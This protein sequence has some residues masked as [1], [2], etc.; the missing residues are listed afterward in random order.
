MGPHIRNTRHT[1]YVPY[2]RHCRTALVAALASALL[3][4]VSAVSATAASP[5]FPAGTFDGSRPADATIHRFLPDALPPDVPLRDALRPGG[6]PDGSGDTP[7]C[8]APH[9]PGLAA[10]L[11]HDLHAALS[12]RRGTVSVAVRDDLGL[13]CELAGERQY[14]SASVAKVLIMEGLLRRAEKLGR[15]LTRWEAANVR[16]MIVRSDNTA[17]RRLWAAQGHSH[18]NGFLARVRTRATVLGPGGYW[19]LTRTTAT[20]QM[21][22]LGVLTNTRSFLRTRAYGLRLLAD[23]RADQRWGV[24]AGMPRGFKAHVKNGWLPRSTH[25]WRV[26]SVG[27]FSGEGRAYRIVVLTHDNPTKAYGVRTIERIAQVVHRGLGQGRGPGR[28]LTPETPPTPESPQTPETPETPE[29]AVSEE[30]DGSAPY[31][32]LPGWDEPEQDATP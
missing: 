6:G 31:E 30:P 9:A 32:P 8:H 2:V 29:A 14:D 18:L 17:A 27:A 1:R 25:G 20:D 12:S 24:P 15:S 23:V 16:P 13:V 4:P 7:T 28:A 3:T 19:G 5:R 26:H 10:R 11:S 22:L 21:R